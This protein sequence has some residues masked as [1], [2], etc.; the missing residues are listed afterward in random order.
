MRR[1]SRSLKAGMSVALVPM[2]LLAFCLAMGQAQTQPVPRMPDGKPN[3]TGVWQALGTA[4]W[5]I[6]DHSA[7]AGSFYQLGAIGAIRGGRG[8]VDG[9][10]IPYQSWAAEKKKENFANR[11]TLD[12]EIKCY[13]PGV[14]RATYLPFPFQ[15]IQSQTNLAIVYEYRTANRLINVAHH[16]EPSVDTWMGW[17]NGHWE[18][19]T[20]VVEVAGL[21]G[22]SWF[23]RAGN[24]ASENVRIVERYAFADPDHLNYEATIDDKTVFTRSWKISLPLYRRKE[25]NAQLT[26]FKCVEFTEEMLYGHLRKQADK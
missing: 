11:L 1:Q 14:P 22:Q 20:L 7:Q 2:V 18:G 15:I 19:D 24:F 4:H 25:M 6:Q 9:N 8:I 10:E 17:S 21:N 13:L 3:F 26:E 16:R 5:D 23:D 12:P